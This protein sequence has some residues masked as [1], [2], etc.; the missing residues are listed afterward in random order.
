[1]VATGQLLVLFITLHV[2]GYATIFFS[3]LNA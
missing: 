2:L 1:M 3:K